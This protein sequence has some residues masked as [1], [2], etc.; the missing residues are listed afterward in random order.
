MNLIQFIESERIKQKL[1]KREI[2]TAAD[3]TPQYYDKLIRGES[4]GSVAIIELLIKKVGFK[5]IPVP[6]DLLK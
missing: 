6:I 5:L 3:I 2:S 4:L 1:T